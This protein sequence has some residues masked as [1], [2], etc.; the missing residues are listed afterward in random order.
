MT[1]ANSQETALTLAPSLTDLRKDGAEEVTSVTSVQNRQREA[2]SIAFGASNEPSTEM[3]ALQ[4]VL[5]A[6]QSL[7]PS[8]EDRPTSAMDMSSSSMLRPLPLP[9]GCRVHGRFEL[10]DVLGQGGMSTVYRALDHIRVRSRASQAEV[11]LKVIDVDRQARYEAVLLLH[12]EARRLQE[13]Q[14]PN[15]V[16][17]FDSAEDGQVHYIVMELL[18]GATLSE[19]IKRRA[20]YLF[21]S[22]EAMRM[23]Q[24]IGAAL[25]HAH[26][27]GIVHGDV[28]PG[29]IFLCR[30]GEIKVIDFGT[31]H[32][33]ARPDR[34]LDAEAT[35]HF[36]G[37]LGVVTPAYA[38]LEMLRGEAP[39]LADDV[40]SLALVIYLILTGRHP[41]DRKSAETASIEGRLPVRPTDLGIGRWAVLRKGLAFERA[42]RF[43]DIETLLRRF[44]RP[45]W[46]DYLAGFRARR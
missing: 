36:V 20:G 5:E 19:T 38:S 11:A 28:K 23:I 37:R 27:R 42:D 43:G 7:A 25:I 44:K 16:R 8:K 9:L 34:Q 2:K 18:T 10:V 33:V 3:T 40:Y 13:L 12:R 35:S 45:T 29:N 31:A 1:N 14:H 4:P 26:S 32:A 30:N 39:A 41:F 21:D 6:R 17:V 46:R 22:A 15:I 24:G